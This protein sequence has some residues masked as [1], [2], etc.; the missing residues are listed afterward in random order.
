MS[1]L[2]SSCLTVWTWYD[3]CSDHRYGMKNIQAPFEIKSVKC[4]RL[5][6]AKCSRIQGLAVIRFISHQNLKMLITRDKHTRSGNCTHKINIIFAVLQYL[7]ASSLS[8]YESADS[9]NSDKFKFCWILNLTCTCKII[10]SLTNYIIETKTQT[11]KKTIASIG[12]Q[13]MDFNV[14]LKAL[15]KSFYEFIF[16]F[17]I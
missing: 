1:L 13:E 10:Q 17:Y 5:D 3:V 15:I 4:R 6:V 2:E 7:N 14:Q 11:T 8:S 12:W 9:R 16:I